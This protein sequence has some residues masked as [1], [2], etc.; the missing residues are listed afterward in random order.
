MTRHLARWAAG[1]P[2]LALALAGCAT[3]R[4]AATLPDRLDLGRNRAGEP[5]VALRNRGDPAV[6][7]P[8]GFWQSYFI[9]CRSVA[10]NRPVGSVRVVPDRA[11]AIGPIERTLACGE[12]TDTMLAAGAATA[13][14]C[15]DAVLAAETVRLDVALANGDRMV[16]SAEAAQL[17]PLERAM[18]LLAGRRIDPPAEGAP[19]TTALD[20]AALAP[21]PAVPA[22]DVARSASGVFDPAIALAEGIDLNHKSLNVEASRILNDALSRLPAAA[23]PEVRAQLQLEAGL[24]DSNISFTSSALEHFEAADAAI[25]MMEPAGRADLVR[26]RDA[27]RAL[28]L[29]NRGQFRSALAALDRLGASETVAGGPLQDPATLRLLNQSARA[30][31]DASRALATPDIPALR[32]DVLRATTNWAKS[33]A[34]LAMGDQAG[35]RAALEQASQA[36]MPLTGENIDQGQVLWLGARIER[37]RGRLAQR[38]GDL[39]GAQAAFDRAIDYLRRGTLANAGTGTEPAIAETQLERAGI[40]AQASPGSE[41]ARSDYAQAVDALIESSAFGGGLPNGIE[42]YLDL[43]VAEA[44]SAP[45]ADTHERFFRAMQATGEPAVARQ[46]SQ[47]QTVVTAEPALAALLRDRTDVQ[48][49][50][51][52]LRYAI[53][54]AT[55]GAAGGGTGDLNREREAAEARLVAIDDRLAADPRYKLVDD[56]PATLAEIR[57][58]LGPGE[59]Y[60]KLTELNRRVYGLFV[61]TDRSFA[62]RIAGTAR[63]VRELNALGAA[64]RASIDGRVASEGRLV[65]FQD[66]AAYALFRLIAGPAADA[67]R[68]SAA[69]VVDPA[70]PLAKLPIGALVTEFDPKATRPAPFDYSRT[71]FLAR[72][73]TI[74]T[75][76]SPRSFLVARALPQSD[77]P[78]PF[79]GLGE[80]QRAGTGMTRGPV[81]V[82]FGC[83]V[84]FATLAT[85]S[86]AFEP[87]SAR[88]LTVA[89]NALG[90]PAAPRIV[91]AAFTDT[92]VIERGAADGDMQQF[93][94]LHFAT[95]GLEEGQ[96]GCPK[97]PPALVTSF[98]DEQSDGLLSFSEIAGL[99]LNANLVVLSACDTASGVTNEALA[100][101]SGQ[102]EAGSTL[103]GLVRAFLAANAR[104]VLATY[105]QVSAEQ[106]SEDFIRT[107]YATARAGTMGGALQ[108]AQRGLIA[109]PE[110][111]HPFYWAPYFIVGDSTKAVLSGAAR[112]QVGAPVVAAR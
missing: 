23:P 83:T 4:V 95:H 36:F 21:P 68:Q 30:P 50:I 41:R 77:A 9:T 3:T 96:W 76:T 18:A 40:I 109:R 73:T 33:T 46:L 110:F 51:T 87:I 27:Y 79:L 112:E 74:S 103:E 24:A 17:A 69:L 16:G 44:T 106:E 8:N 12:A 28:D 102:E 84:P 19:V 49:E 99:R 75:A 7:D 48:R 61:T 43:L 45:R 14:R 34:L 2:L 107:F 6:T 25:A 54:D 89:A 35:A 10:A 97:S 78:R 60:F 53:A 55:G 5:C 91:D 85:L 22:A 108:A 88:E 62:Y 65:P 72:D 81:S 82:G 15:N 1:A 26:K 94:V 105:W 80:H 64:V 56:R 47:L 93:Q 67:I 90:A 39:A 37:Q 38:A 86:N 29:I 101:A 59:G 92:G 98:G 70:G 57:A 11:D 100:R 13:R 32:R 63:D 104:A 52:R 58:A 71:A 66:G 42:G 31:G 20:Q 111:S